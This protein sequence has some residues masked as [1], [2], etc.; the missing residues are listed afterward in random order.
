MV[1]R[2]D[3]RAPKGD[4]PMTMTHKFSKVSGFSGDG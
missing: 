4:A 3:E 2:N 1:K